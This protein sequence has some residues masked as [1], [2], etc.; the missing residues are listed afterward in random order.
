MSLLGCWCCYRHNTMSQFG[1]EP[2]GRR[3]RG[4]YGAY[5]VHVCGKHHVCE[6]S[7]DRCAEHDINGGFGLVTGNGFEGYNRDK[8]KGVSN[9]R[10]LQ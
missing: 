5:K 1:G 7:F 9:W 4:F 2:E 10:N 3:P 6:S 8:P